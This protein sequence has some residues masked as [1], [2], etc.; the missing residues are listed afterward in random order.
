MQCRATDA[1]SEKSAAKACGD[2]RRADRAREGR[3]PTQAS[4][5]IFLFLKWN[6]EVCL[7]GKKIKDRAYTEGPG[8][9]VTAEVMPE[10]WAT[11][12]ERGRLVRPDYGG[13]REIEQLH[14][15]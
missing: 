1:T 7:E 6:F 14:N 2:E 5:P 15:I 8:E 13:E 4:T 9:L 3:Y 12:I 11:R 10:G